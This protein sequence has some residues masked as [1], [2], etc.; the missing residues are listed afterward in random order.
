MAGVL[1]WSSEHTD[2]QVRAWRRRVA[3]ERAGEAQRDDDS[4][5]AAYRAALTGEGADSS[6]G[7][8]EARGTPR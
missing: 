5:L 7:K 6:D 4:A 8:L 2:Q 1:G 3:A